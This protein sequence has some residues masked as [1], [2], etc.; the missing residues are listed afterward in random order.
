MRESC[1][2]TYQEF[3]LLFLRRLV[4]ETTGLD[5]LVVDIELV[6][7]TSIHSFFDTLL[8]DETEDADSLCLADTVSTILGLKISVGIPEESSSVH[9]S[10]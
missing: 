6:P 7:R 4:V 1:C 9:L 5:D 8:R 3:F 10:K 2:S